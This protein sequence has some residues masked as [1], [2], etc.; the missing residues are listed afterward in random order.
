[1]QEIL[2]E[3]TALIEWYKNHARGVIE[4]LASDRVANFDAQAFRLEHIATLA[5]SEI[6]AC[7]LGQSGVGKSTLINAIVA[8]YSGAPA[9]DSLPAHIKPPGQ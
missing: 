6:A 5:G 4:E 3:I 7:F 2:S 1:M 9:P 8:H